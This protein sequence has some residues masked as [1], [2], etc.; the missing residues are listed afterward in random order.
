MAKPKVKCEH[1]GKETSGY[2]PY[3]WTIQQKENGQQAHYNTGAIQPI[4]LVL[5]LGLSF[6]EGNVVKYVCR[7]K[8]S[9]TPLEDLQDAR[10]YLDALID[11]WKAEHAKPEV[12][13]W[14]LEELSVGGT[15]ER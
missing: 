15:R 5:E 6:P 14:K 10:N 13:E 12:K 11:K 7:Y 4:D 8:K 2:Y 3:S 9:D 1:C